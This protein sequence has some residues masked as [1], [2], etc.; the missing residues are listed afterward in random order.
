VRGTLAAKPA[1]KAELPPPKVKAKRGS[2][3]PDLA[4][5]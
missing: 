3:K 2:K 4:A 1:P 5:A